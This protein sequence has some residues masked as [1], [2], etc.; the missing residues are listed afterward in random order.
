L[1]F[2][3]I[4][5]ERSPRIDAIRFGDLVPP[6]GGVVFD[7]TVEPELVDHLP[8]VV[9]MVVTQVS[10]YIIRKAIVSFVVEVTHQAVPK[11]I[12]HGCPQKRAGKRCY[13]L[14]V[15]QG[16]VVSRNVVPEDLTIGAISVAEGTIQP[17]NTISE[18]ASAT[19][20][21][22]GCIQYGRKRR[23]LIDVEVPVQVGHRLV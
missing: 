5:K 22:N 14:L 17:I 20:A 19:T 3:G 11:V 16:S 9:A 21:T 23:P 12:V 15:R 6:A 18:G 1:I 4:V 10:A 7:P 2:I 13:P 8:E